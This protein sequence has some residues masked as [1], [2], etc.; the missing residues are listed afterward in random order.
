[1]EWRPVDGGTGREALEAVGRSSMGSKREIQ[2]ENR[3]L[4]CQ[5]ALPCAEK[6]M[7]FPL[8]V[9]KVIYYWT[10]FFRGTSAN[11]RFEA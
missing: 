11:G 9:L 3:F 6:D 7:L 4:A 5:T 10:H 8:L 2:K 1:M